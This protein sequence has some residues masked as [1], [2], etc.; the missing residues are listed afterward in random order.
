MKGID[1]IMPK[2]PGK[3]Y[4]NTV[5][6]R[7][8]AVYLHPGYIP[9]MTES[10]AKAK[11]VQPGPLND[12]AI[13]EIK[14]D[15]SSDIINRLMP[16]CLPDQ[17]HQL[18]VGIQC[19]IMGHGFMNSH[20]EDNFVMPSILQMADVQVSSN[21]ACRDDVE[22]MSIKS[23]IN[24][25]TICVRGPIHPCV[26]DSGGP[27][28]CV[29]KSSSYIDGQLTNYDFEDYVDEEYAPR[30]KWYLNGVTSFAVS[31]D[32]HD[33]CGQFKSAVF[34]KVSHYI[35]WAYSVMNR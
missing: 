4:D 21:Q 22:S 8:K 17:D 32:E 7:A 27:L 28:L 14:H 10:E 16:I 24:S 6:F 20:D 18:N 13:I 35:N 9:A 5:K 25:D 11:G 3:K 23:K 30:S 26:G 1:V 31:T 15:P 33:K 2:I 29:G 19:K 34:T 12:I